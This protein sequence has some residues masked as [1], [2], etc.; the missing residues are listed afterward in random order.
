[1]GKKLY[2]KTYRFLCK[3]AQNLALSPPHIDINLSYF[4]HRS[5]FNNKT[6]QIFS[7]AKLLYRGL[8]QNGK[9]Y[10]NITTNNPDD[11]AGPLK[12]LIGRFGRNIT[13][14]VDSE[15]MLQA[16]Y[17]IIQG[18][19]HKSKLNG[20]VRIIGTLPNDPN[21]V[22]E[23]HTSSGLGFLGH[24]KNGVPSGYCWKGLLGGSWVY[25]KVDKNGD[26]SGEDIAYIN[27]DVKTAYKG[28]FDNGVMIK[29]KAVEVIGE[30]CND[31]GMK[32]LEFSDPLSAQEYHFERPT[33]SSF[34]DQPLVIDPLDDRYIRLGE[35]HIDTKEKSRDSKQNG[36]FA[37]VDIPPGTMIGHYNGYILSEKEIKKQI[38][39][40]QSLIDGKVSFYN[41]LEKDQPV[42]NDLIDNYIEATWKYRTTMK[43]GKILDIPIEEGQDSAKYN[44]TRGHKLNHSFHSVN[45]QL[46]YYDSARFGITIS[47]ISREGLTIE[48]GAE[49]FH[50]YGYGYSAGPRWYK[51]LFKAFMSEKKK[52]SEGDIKHTLK[53]CHFM[54]GTKMSSLECENYLYD[55]KNHLLQAFGLTLGSEA[56]DDMLNTIIKKHQHLANQ[57]MQRL[58]SITTE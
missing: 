51:T 22:C 3:R 50:H 40:H 8:M 17:F 11:W 42:I 54:D 48:K 47:I 19:L 20:M 35:S 39:Q 10:A 58:R 56:T 28:M 9:I 30:R 31:E 18:Q 43:C 29:A 41:K 52:T 13:F 36:A 7:H 14:R 5:F 15:E 26:F 53:D 1:M 6:Y 24:Y 27:Q 38:L 23:E 44:S 49:L 57:P 37:M 46:S 25:G 16:R 4:N 33:A 34:G 12:I 32:I 21:D 45:T 2:I 55:L